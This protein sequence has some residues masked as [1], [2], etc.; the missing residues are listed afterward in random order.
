MK[1]RL[2]LCGL[3]TVA[4]IS[5]CTTVI[6]VEEVRLDNYSISLTPGQTGEI[7]ATVFPEGATYERFTW[8]SSNS[9]VVS[10]SDGTITALQP[11]ESS[12]TASAN[13]V[14]SKPCKVVVK[15]IPVSRIDLNST[16]LSLIEEETFML[17]AEVYPANATY[18]GV[19]FV[20]SNTSVATVTSGG[21]VYAVKEGTATIT[22]RSADGNA[23]ASCTV[24]VKS[25]KI[26]VTGVSLDKTSLTMTEGDTQSLT[27]TVTPSNATDKSVS[28]SSNNTSVAEVSSTGV[29]IARSAG[30][31]TITVKTTDGAKTATCAVTV[32]AKVISVTG[33]SLDKTSLTLTEGDTQTLTATVTPSNATDKSVT[34]SSNNASVAEVSSTGVVFARSVGT[35]TITV[36]TNDGGKIATCLVTVFVSVTGVS[37]NQT[38]L[39]MEVGDTKTLTATV[40]PS[41]ATDKR[42]IWSSSNTSVATVSSSG[43]VIAKSLG[44]ATI[45]VKTAEGSK[46]ASCAVIVNNQENRW[47]VDNDGVNRGEGVI[48]DGRVWAPVNCGYEP[49]SAPKG[50]YYQWGR[51]NGQKGES[52][53]YGFSASD[54][55]DGENGKED[56]NTVYCYRKDDLNSP[57]RYG[58]D[59][60]VIGDNHFWNAGTEERPIKTE[61][62]PCPVGWRVPTYSELSSLCKNQHYEAHEGGVWVS[63]GSQYS[64][65]LQE[66]LF[67]PS[68]GARWAAGYN[69]S[70]CFAG[71]WGAYWTSLASE[72]GDVSY[73]RL[74]STT[75]GFTYPRI[76]RENSCTIRCI[77]E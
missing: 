37:L 42:V 44:S 17:I 16:S 67:L 33:V 50:L 68:G 75:Y 48:V 71:L 3:I 39:S 4:A 9:S 73:V 34:W 52:A 64:S 7:N 28:W 27:A 38:S 63:G 15:A 49:N 72:S 21:S 30:T 35:A 51:K 61:Y 2:L 59:W 8:N 6:E 56:P 25:K 20:S 13:G 22:C 74:I 47:Y 36:K 24:T 43:V 46:T 18:K 77:R 31:A 32:K 40:T 29:V 45:T 5:A 70:I 14:S 23:S 60:I 66:K 58:G 26:S 53:G 69:F 76:R 62:D 11:G 41:N 19:E 10:V 1:I 12:I 65:D 57:A 54:L 55:W